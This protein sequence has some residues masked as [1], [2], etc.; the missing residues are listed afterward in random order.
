MLNFT[1]IDPN[2]PNRHFSVNLSLKEK[3]TRKINQQNVTQYCTTSSN[4][5]YARG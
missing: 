5:S 1:N 3:W 2:D 4:I